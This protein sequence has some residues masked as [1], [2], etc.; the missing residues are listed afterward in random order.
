MNKIMKI[1]VFSLASVVFAGLLVNASPIQNVEAYEDFISELHRKRFIEVEVGINFTVA[2]TTDHEVYTF[3]I[4]SVGQ[5]GINSNS[6]ASKNVPSNITSSFA[7]N[8]GEM[9]VDI[10]AGSNHVFASTNQNRIFAWGANNEGQLG[11]GN[12]LDVYRPSDVTS[13]WNASASK[14]VKQLVASNFNTIILF[15]DNTLRLAGANGL[16]MLLQGN[17]LTYTTPVTANITAWLSTDTIVD[18]NMYNEHGVILTSSG[19]IGTWGNNLYWQLGNN[20]QF[21]SSSLITITLPGLI[22]GERAISV[23]AGNTHTVAITNKDK[24]FFIGTNSGYA[25]GNALAL[26]ALAKTPTNVSSFFY[27][28]QG[29]NTYPYFGIDPD[30]SYGERPVAVYAGN[31]STFFKTIEISIDGSTITEY[32]EYVDFWSLGL[33]KNGSIYSIIAWNEDDQYILEPYSLSYNYFDD[34]TASKISF[35]STNHFVL[36]TEGDITMFGS[37]VWGQMGL[38]TT[39]NV[40][41]YYNYNWSPNFRYFETYIYPNL[42]NPDALSLPLDNYFTWDNTMPASRNDEYNAIFGYWVNDFYREKGAIDYYFGDIFTDK[43]LQLYLPEQLST[44]REIFAIIFTDEI[45]HGYIP[46]TN[47]AFYDELVEYDGDRSGWRYD[48]EYFANYGS[49]EM[50]WDEEIFLDE[51]IIALLS[52]EVEARLD[53]FRLILS[54]LENFEQNF[55]ANFIDVL[56]D[57]E[58]SNPDEYD[59]TW[60]DE[61]DNTV[62]FDL[63]DEAIFTLIELGYG[64]DILAIFDAYDE[65]TELEQ[66]LLTPYFEENYDHLYYAYYDAFANAYADQL[67][68]FEYNIQDGD[69][70]W[71]WPLFENLTNLETLLGGIEG[72]NPISL[73][74]FTDTYTDQWGDEY[75]NYDMYEYWIWLNDLLPHL[76]EGKDVFEQIVEIENIIQ[77]E[78]GYYWV[79]LENVP[80]ILA[81][82]QDFLSLSEDAQ[83]LLDPEYV[84]WI[85]SLALEALAYDVE[86]ELWNI[87]NIQD[88]SGTYG[89]FANYDDV[90]ATLEAYEALPE[91]ALQY[92][93]EEAIAYYEYLL[94]IK[95]ALEEGLGVFDQ[96]M[97]IENFDLENLDDTTIE[98]ISNMYQDYLEL[99]EEAQQLLDPEYVEWLVSLATSTV[100]GNVG[101]LPATVEDF[102]ALFN[103]AETKDATVASLL[104]AWRN[105]QAMSDEVKD[106][107]DAEARAQLEAIYARYLELT[108]PTVDLIMIGLILVHL[109]AG[110]YFAFKKREVLVKTINE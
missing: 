53:D 22:S 63:Y 108:R 102:D 59:F 87:W 105:Y 11:T 16:G 61:G 15:T 84:N 103:D 75:Y 64:D 89:L 62:W 49:W 50:S 23:A 71:Y 6:I 92:L 39:S 34:A 1:S 78:D 36:N 47:E 2:L 57:L 67:F 107:M 35:S 40:T 66:L 44:M 13:F 46:A 81:M 101:E 30:Y 96:I 31:Y 72:L 45:L 33:N 97:D 4:N 93:D 52:P 100:E 42:P 38:G 29:D 88:E 19:K 26:N 79:N 8:S 9:I 24:V 83:N 90:I 104:N 14:T 54:N 85:Y 58:T 82:Y 27:S 95:L 55:I 28:P 17:F 20:T 25:I 69:W 98:A 68:D 109:S 37:N 86:D 77:N 41:E 99:S 65:L 21:S 106:M 43:E 80:S 32:P 91:D 110:V 12:T 7:L 10:D 70:G 94:S 60:T 56:K 76:Q 18:V 74:I 73:G 3:G 5:L 51:E 48:L